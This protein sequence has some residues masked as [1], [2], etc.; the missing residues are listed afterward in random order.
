MP[1]I[2]NARPEDLDAIAA[3]EALCFPPAEAATRE[4][5]AARLAHYPEGF[6]L[7]EEGGALCA[8]ADGFATDE[9]DLR[10]E[11]YEN[12]AL[13]DA[14][15][16]WQMVFGLNTRPDCRGR[17]YASALL[18]RV[19]ADAREKRRRGVVLTC[20]AALLPFYARLGFSDEGVTE[21][22]VHGGAVWHQM[23]LTLE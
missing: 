12:A 10:D 3:L 22:S 8:F 21:K 7:L 4:D 18:R 19:I 16:A 6:W 9:P 5:F 20:K 13:H 17:G 15:G 11:M 14:H 1:T 23:R 2:R